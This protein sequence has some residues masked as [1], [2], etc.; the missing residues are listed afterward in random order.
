MGD[1]TTNYLAELTASLTAE[2]LKGIGRKLRAAIIGTEKEQ[3]IERCLRI[4]IAA[5]LAAS[6]TSSKDET[7]QLANIFRKFFAEPDVGKELGALLRGLPLNREE[8]L[9]LFEHAGF[10]AKTLPGVRFEPAL[11]AFET[12]FLIAATDERELQGTIQ[13]NQLLAQT[14]L[15][16]EMRDSMRALVDSLRQARL[17]T[18]AIHNGG[19]SAQNRAGKVVVYQ[20]PPI[21]F[22]GAG[23]VAAAP[24]ATAIG[25]VH[26]NVYL[27]PPAQDPG[28]ALAIYCRVLVSAC[29]HLPLRGVDIGASD[30]TG[31]QQ[32]LDLA[33]VYVNLDTKTQVPLSEEKTKQ[34]QQRAKVDEQKTRPLGV[35]EATIQNHRLVILGDPGSGKSTFVNHL[36]LCLAG[37]KLEPQ[38]GW[39]MRLSGWPKSE[40]D[41]VPITVILRDF[42]RWVPADAKKPEPRHLWDFILTRLEAQNLAFVAAPLEAALEKGH[43]VVLLDGLDEIPTQKQRTFIRDAVA[44]FFTRYAKSR[45]VVTCRKLSYQ[46]PAWQLQG[47]P[48]FELAPFDKEKIEHFI[49]AWYAELARLAVVKPEEAASSAGRLLQAIRRPDLWRLAPNPLLLTVMAL[50]HTHKGQ[51]PDARALLYEET[52]DILLWRWEQLKTA[53]EQETPTLRQLLL[54]AGRIDVDLKRKLWQL[55]FEAHQQGKATDGE[56]LADVSE[57]Q[58]EKKLAELHPEQSHDWARQMIETMKHRAGL[59]LERVPEVYTFP[60]RTFQE[61]L[62]GAHLSRQADF[63]KQVIRLMAEGVFWREVIL[64]AV[65]R[66][67]YLS[68]DTDKP[69]ALVGE[70]CPQPISDDDSAWRNAWL[71]GEVLAEMGL[72]RVEDTNL[73]RDLAQRV[74]QRLVELMKKHRLTAVERAA[75]GNALARL[76]DPRF[77]ADAWFLPDEP[78]L[79]FKK[80]PAG[81]FLMGSDKKKDSQAY[82]DELEQHKIKLPLYYIARYPVTVAQFQSFVNESNYKPEHPECLDGLPNHPVV[83]VTWHEALAYCEWMTERLRTWEGTPEPI[84]SLLKKQGWRV[85]LPSEAEW[86][87]AARWTDGRIYPWGN[88]ADANRAN[89][90]DTGIGAT[91]AVGCLHDGK[92]LYG[93]EEMSGN[94]WEWTRSL[95]EDYPYPADAKERVKRENL[96]AP[97][98]KGRVWRGG[99]FYNNDWG[100]RCA[101]RGR[102][103]PNLWD[104]GLGFRVAVLPLL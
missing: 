86:E 2:I 95:W 81:E 11:T 56:A 5:L 33:Q 34:R 102:Y 94:V 41:L 4:G 19:I 91:S 8:L 58:L 24:G 62:A 55:A 30:P 29:R 63:A 84:A 23:A 1:F 47:F 49:K 20:L 97:S 42:A 69:L 26:G 85:T 43:A 28:E 75:A 54:A 16:G 3:A 25:T 7:D 53:G 96:E 88:E 39:L 12:A 40:T 31:G 10:E 48:D 93:C 57:W 71:A 27:G 73:G 79:G 46:D 77:R 44:A 70:L 50:V 92:S 59:I 21:I 82:D 76:G 15:L 90:D 104:D 51:L 65:G 38:A 18:L 87:K 35:L 78:L 72:N 32:R 37:Q 36:A 103:D 100:V 52:V 89:Y 66:L 68:G 64:L 98:D 6:S 13:T 101:A 61:Y 22:Q 9:Y 74:R 80:I 45:V 14:H 17:D 83:Y 99:A 60:H 67:V